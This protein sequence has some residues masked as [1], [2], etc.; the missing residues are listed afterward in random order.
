MYVCIPS[1]RAV[2]ARGTGV[3]INFGPGPAGG[4]ILLRCSVRRAG[5]ARR[6]CCLCIHDDC[7][8]DRIRRGDGGEDCVVYFLL[9]VHSWAML[10][11]DVLELK[12]ALNRVDSRSLV[13]PFHLF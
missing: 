4:L 13:Q 12:S 7:G 8:P 2:S 3:R 11:N 6:L 1:G 5:S 9:R 10:L